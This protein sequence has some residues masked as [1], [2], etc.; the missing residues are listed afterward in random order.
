MSTVLNNLQ[1]DDAESQPRSYIPPSPPV[2]LGQFSND[3]RVLEDV[4]L[5]GAPNPGTQGAE[6]RDEGAL[7]GDFIEAMRAQYGEGTKSSP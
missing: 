2:P 5:D 3:K 4:G 1:E 6:N 7:F